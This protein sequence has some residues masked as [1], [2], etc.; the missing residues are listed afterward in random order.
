[1]VS[2]LPKRH[3]KKNTRYLLI[4]ISLSNTERFNFSKVEGFPESDNQEPIEVGSSFKVATGVYGHVVPVGY[5]FT[6]APKDDRVQIV[7]SIRNWTTDL[8]NL[9][10]IQR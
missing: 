3:R 6:N 1:M 9:I 8:K 7:F 5:E 10:E 2:H 4:V